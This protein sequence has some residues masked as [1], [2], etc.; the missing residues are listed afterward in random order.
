[1]RA[2]EEALRDEGAVASPRARSPA[3]SAPQGWVVSEPLA[4]SE[5]TSALLRRHA[6]QPSS[7][8]LD[9]AD[10]EDDDDTAEDESGAAAAAAAAAAIE[11]EKLRRRE[12]FP[13]VVV[14][15]EGWPW[16][17]SLVPKPDDPQASAL[18]FES[19]RPLVQA[20]K[21]E[22]PWAHARLECTIGASTFTAFIRGRKVSRQSLVT[23]HDMRA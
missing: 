2:R 9:C 5:A 18:A 1:M 20:L 12:E 23:L 15:G 3:K 10:L 19:L 22:A 7:L 6:L 11:N 21:E 8:A 14:Q 13:R 17:A 16:G 4:L